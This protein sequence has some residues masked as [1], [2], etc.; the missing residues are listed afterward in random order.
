MS[1]TGERAKATGLTD[2]AVAET[3]GAKERSKK[4]SGMRVPR[5][6]SADGVNPF[7]QVEWD[8]RSAAIKD[9]T[10]RA[11]F[12][13]HDCEIPK[14]WSQLATN[15]VVSKYFYGDPSSGNGSPAEG[16]REFSVRQLIDRVT[17]TI[18]DWGREDGY[19]ATPED[20]DRFH[21]EL[22]A[23]CLNQY[24]S[25]N[26]P[27]WFNVGLFHNYGIAG[28]AN[29]WRWD[30]ETRAIVPA[31]SAY[32]TP[33]ASAC[34]IQSVSDDMEGIMRL[35]TS[36]AMLF[37][38]GSGTGTDLSTLRS[39]RE[40]L[41]GGGKPSGPVS[42]MK[43]YDAVA[44]VVKSGG[45]TRRAAKM[46]TLKCWH[47]DILEFIECKTKEEAKA[48]ALIR[49]GYE[50]NF[51]GE[52]YS[53]VNF[54]NANLSVR[55]SDDFLKAAENDGEWTTRAV[56]TG[57]P[58]E[59]YKARM[60]LDKIAEGTWLCGDP[61]VQYE[62]T[63][64]R[65][66]TCPNTAPINS[67]NPCVT[68]ET[69]VSTAEGYRRIADLVGQEVI[70]VDRQGVRRPAKRVFPTGRKP[71]YRLTTQSGYQ[72]RLTADHRVF[73]VNR[74]DV[75]A[76]ELTRDDRIALNPVGF[77]TDDLDV[78]TAEVIGLMLGDGCISRTRKDGEPIAT[79]T[80]DSSLERSI[81]EEVRDRLNRL[82][83]NA[84][85]GRTRREVELG[86]GGLA[87]VARLATGS[88]AVAEVFERYAVLDRGSAGK[89]LR[90]AAFDLDRR[91]VAGLLR[92]LFTA[93]GCVYNYGVKSQSISLDSVSL[94][95]LRQV[96]LLLLGFGIKA[97]LYTN[98]RVGPL[99]AEMPDGKGGSKT[100]P[101]LQTHSL[102]I[103]RS[104]RV[105]FEKEIGFW[106][107][108]HKQVRL[109]LLNQ[110]VAAYSDRMDDAVASLEADGVEDV[111]D[112]TEPVTSHFGA[113]GLVVHNCSEYMF[114]D[115]SACN[116]ASLNLVRFVGEDGVFDVEKFRA[117][118]R[119]FITAQ[120]ILVDHA[121]YPTELIGLNSHKFRPLGLGYANLGS[122]LMSSGLPYDSDEG[123]ALAA[124]IT[125]V[126]HGQAYLTSAEH[127]GQVGPFEGFSLNREPMLKVM[128]MHREA[129]FAIDP[130][131]PS[132]LLEA[133]RSIWDECLET[134]RKNGYR[135]SQVTVLA[136]TGTIAFM[137]DCDTT[138]IEPDIA[139]VK[140]KLLAGG[141]MLKIVNRTVPAAMTKLGYDEP[142]IRGVLDYIDANDTIEGAPG[143]KDEDLPVF[144]CAFAPPQ[145]GRSIHYRGH[146]RMMAAV[147]PFL[148]GAISKTCNMPN[149]A[150]VEEIRDTYLEGWKLGLK[151]LAIY[152]DGSKGSQPVSTKAE[153]KEKEKAAE[154]TA[155]PDRS[156]TAPEATAAE[157]RPKST[158]VAGAEGGGRPRRERLPHTRRSLTHKF[159]IQGHE[160]YINVGFYPD[161][162]PG[163]LF[164]TMAKEGSTIG[165][166]MDVLGTSISIGLQY[167][168]P[169][170]VFVNKFAHSR[171]EPAGF[172]KNPD[173]PIAK[174]I[175]DYIFRWLG[176]EFIEGYREA[177]S[178]NRSAVEPA[179]EPES[180]GPVVKVNGHRT[181]TMADLEHAEAIMGTG[182]IPK[183]HPIQPQAPE[184]GFGDQERQF[185]RF[186]SDAPACDNCGA[187]TVRCGTCYRCFNCGN[188]MGCS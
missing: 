165:G 40:R 96:Q 46:Q 82:K 182:P 151:A 145:G 15:V 48:Q 41:A 23:L 25:F 155:E 70:L 177:N 122:L 128:E 112:L 9:E 162:R 176:M 92:G 28:P 20:A 62:D 126:M 50:A 31:T 184:P 99:A 174:S 53:S 47:P 37:K 34:F 170:E 10:G 103:S 186:Q 183:A 51:N 163:E 59:T 185:A 58:M 138:G 149:S 132:H 125:A 140:Y 118:V 102:R 88:R 95:L 65:W 148:S 19:F 78:E 36:E 97:K 108:S 68:G 180:Q 55:C 160:G 83:S 109:E 181:A 90:D 74:G 121:S 45:K 159:D 8:F 49:E 35:A 7:D 27:V 152:R 52:A 5:V 18:A 76:C 169:L 178:P 129:A 61:G 144:D 105:R 75:A 143:I 94:D 150:T 14:S 26:S 137:M 30:E 124:A 107:G 56:V 72:L 38:F 69:L 33:Q 133:A 66:H 172:T 161:G 3:E 187:L 139:L 73:T 147:Q 4:R 114:V 156:E 17:R 32:E 188:S 100:Y 54:Q 127:A 24:G 64:Q 123:R 153:G 12:E 42:F 60:L 85:D 157:L 39:S 22:T 119:V 154:E 134:G 16:K 131:A 98:R 136:P 130:S 117:A 13:Q 115:D 175:A 21:D 86:E 111:F 135:N 168:V 167:G 6:F 120:E 141:G 2:Q 116:L 89:Q 80:M 158:A 77:G 63:I 104:S 110:T 79:L 179:E 1:K 173:I 113:N 29:N 81:V 171:F 142:T 164:I 84:A 166:L 106:P 91:A 11:L 93:D 146:L 44:S 43:V 87:T 57:R 71:V 67:S 101:V